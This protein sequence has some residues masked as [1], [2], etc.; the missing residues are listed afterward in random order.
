MKRAP[1]ES[2]LMSMLGWKGVK[3]ASGCS[4]VY[5]G[6]LVGVKTMENRSKIPNLFQSVMTD[7]LGCS[8]PGAA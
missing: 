6:R 3:D 8:E 2:Q 1:R 5:R 4:V 7:F